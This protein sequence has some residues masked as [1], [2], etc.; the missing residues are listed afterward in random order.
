MKQ[1]FVVSVFILDVLL[2]MY[3]QCCIVYMLWLPK[4]SQ[5]ADS[6]V[7]ELLS[8]YRESICSWISIKKTCRWS[9]RTIWQFWMSSQSKRYEYGEW[10]ET[11]AGKD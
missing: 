4:I 3:L 8:I 10:D 9:I 1:Y 2:Q 6:I 5:Y 7:A 11:M